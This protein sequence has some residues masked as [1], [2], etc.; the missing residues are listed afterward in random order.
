MSSTLTQKDIDALLRGADTSG[1]SLRTDVAPFNY[2]VPARISRERRTALEAIYGRYSVTLQALLSSRLRAPVDVSV[3]SVEQATFGEFLMATG[4][5]CSAFIFRVLEG[6]GTH[7]VIDLGGA[8]AYHLVDRLF[9]GPG[10]SD[11][12]PRGLTTLEQAVVRGITERAIALLGEAWDRQLN[13]SPEIIGFESN[14]EMI[15]VVHRDDPVLVVG[16]EVRAGQFAGP[17]ALCLPMAALER[18]LTDGGG[19][20]P[21]N[22]DA[23]ASRE[24][25]EQH[26]LGAH[27][28]LSARIPPFRLTMRAI[29]GLTEGQTLLTGQVPESP[30][31]VM[32]NGTKRYQGSL[33]QVRRRL[34]LRIETIVTQ[35]AA[36]PP[37]REGRVS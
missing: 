35:P 33:G 14:P 18:F 32:V 25:V 23:H 22:V 21:A 28:T 15:H 7:G 29:T 4:S 13:L 37:A 3:F 24:Q 9:G 36:D 6:T 1:H 10:E 16:L 5:P 34:A 19:V 31:D 8:V 30:V 12:P 17:I 2:L 11:P 20:R 26:L 27:V